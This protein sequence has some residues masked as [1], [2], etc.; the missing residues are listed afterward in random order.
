VVAVDVDREVNSVQGDLYYDRDA[1]SLRGVTVPDGLMG[2]W[3]QVETGHIRFA[4]ISLEALSGRR[5]LELAV[6]S[7][8]PLR[9]EDFRVTLDEIVSAEEFRDLT[10]AVVEGRSPVL[11]HGRLD[12]ATRR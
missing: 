10:P 7:G 8:R 4:G 3:N 1:L 2:A 5:L 6:V 9:S 12:A 11:V